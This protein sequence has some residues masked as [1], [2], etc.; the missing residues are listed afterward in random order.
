VMTAIAQ[1]G[2]YGAI[3]MMFF[4]A[5]YYMVPRLTGNVWASSGL[6]G[7]HTALVMFGVVAS[8]VTLFVAGWTQGVNLLNPKVPMS[9]I[10]GDV[11]LSLLMNSG[12]Q[13][14]LLAGNLLLL[15][16]FCRTACGCRATSA[17]APDIFRQ[18]ATLEVHAS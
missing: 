4:G 5:I 11:R 17:P 9:A 3:S 8:V 16:N 12:A 14:L 10:F 6:T 13:L 18:P 2:L 1:L 7:G 15:V